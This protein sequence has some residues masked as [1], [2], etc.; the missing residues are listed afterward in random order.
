MP[1]GNKIPIKSGDPI[2]NHRWYKNEQFDYELYSKLKGKITAHFKITSGRWGG[3]RKIE[4][5]VRVYEG[6]LMVTLDM[7]M[8]KMGV[9][10]GFSTPFSMLNSNKKEFDSKVKI[11]LKHIL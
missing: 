10:Q 4:K 8:F 11:F 3:K 1:T 5:Y 2:P 6:G 7:T 9:N